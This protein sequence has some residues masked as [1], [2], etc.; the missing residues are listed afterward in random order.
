M[1]LA[2]WPH[3]S[4]KNSTPSFSMTYSGT[5][6]RPSST[7]AWTM[8]SPLPLYPFLKILMRRS[9]SGDRMILPPFVHAGENGHVGVGL[10][11]HRADAGPVDI[12]MGKIHRVVF[13]RPGGDV[14]EGLGIEHLPASD[15]G[16]A[17]L[18]GTGT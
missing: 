3:L 10:A 7:L 15:G 4:S 1:F 8:M 6:R 16:T 5:P 2:P 17:D 11:T 14:A 12:E 18:A 13:V 9:I